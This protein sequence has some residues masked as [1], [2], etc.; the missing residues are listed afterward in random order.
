MERGDPL[1]G[2]PALDVGR[3]GLALDHRVAVGEGA[4]GRV[5]A[6]R[7]LVAATV[8]ARDGAGDD[9]VVHELLDVLGGPHDAAHD[10][11]DRGDD[12]NPAAAGEHQCGADDGGRDAEDTQSEPQEVREEEH[13][14]HAGPGRDGDEGDELHDV[15]LMGE[16]PPGGEC[17][18]NDGRNEHACEQER[19]IHDDSLGGTGHFS[20]LRPMLITIT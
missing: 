3:V 11:H 19:Q 5:D 18:G 15:A 17:S 14:P 12:E 1:V 20:V 8:L 7:A 9:A 13:Q 2:D 4:A 16:V 10:Q 6:V